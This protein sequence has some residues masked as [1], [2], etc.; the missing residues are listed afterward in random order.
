MA[1]MKIAL[2][3]CKNIPPT[4]FPPSVWLVVLKKHSSLSF[5]GLCPLKVARGDSPLLLTSGQW[6]VNGATSAR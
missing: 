6:P 4:V 5:L 3:K 1:H 2:L